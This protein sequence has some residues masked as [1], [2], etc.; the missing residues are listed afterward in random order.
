MS[1]ELYDVL[2]HL[3]QRVENLL[4]M[5]ESG[6]LEGFEVVLRDIKLLVRDPVFVKGLD[7]DFETLKKAVD[8]MSDHLRKTVK[9]ALESKN[10]DELVQ[11]IM[12][13]SNGVRENYTASQFKYMD[14]A[15]ESVVSY[16]EMKKQDDKT[17]TI[18]DTDIDKLIDDE[19]E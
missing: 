11:T 12:M 4:N 18:E 17:K 3:P 16:I 6:N 2:M 19:L 1:E 14:D 8:S 7:D 5:K 13:L 15:L 9:D 10:D